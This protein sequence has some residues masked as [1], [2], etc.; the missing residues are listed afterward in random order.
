MSEPIF[1]KEE[2]P[3][4]KRIREKQERYDKIYEGLINTDVGTTGRI[5]IERKEVQKLYS[6]LLNRDKKA[7]MLELYIRNA[8]RERVAGKKYSKLVEGDLYFE[9]VEKGTARRR[10]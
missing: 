6:G 7:R 2:I 8:K 4:I 1:F 9:R 3:K 10:K 5:N